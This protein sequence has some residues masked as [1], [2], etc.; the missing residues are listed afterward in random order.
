LVAKIYANNKEHE[1]FQDKTGDLTA[2]TLTEEALRDGVTDF[3]L[4]VIRAKHFM[5]SSNYEYALTEMNKA[6]KACPN[7]N[8]IPEY[9]ITIYKE[10][11][12]DDLISE[13][14]YYALVKTPS[15]KSKQLRENVVKGTPEF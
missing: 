2:L 7:Y 5:A 10:M 6:M 9:I 1:Y 12:F 13:K 15:E 8:W 3:Q 14:Q 11:L 4:Y